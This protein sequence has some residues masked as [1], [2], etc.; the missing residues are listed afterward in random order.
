[1]DVDLRGELA[2]WFQHFWRLTQLK[3]YEPTLHGRDCSH[4]RLSEPGT[5]APPPPLAGTAAMAA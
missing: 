4:R 2:Y 1:M 3:F 5:G